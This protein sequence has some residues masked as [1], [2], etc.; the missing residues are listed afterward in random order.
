MK[1]VIIRHLPTY[2]NMEDLLQGTQDIE[3]LP[4]NH[5][6]N[7]EIKKNRKKL[8]NEFNFD[9]VLCS[10]LKRTKQ[11]ANLYGYKNL[12]IDPLLNELNFGYFEGKEKSELSKVVNWVENPRDVVLGES[13]IDFEKRIKS[14]I[15]KYI[16]L[17][18]LLIFGH[19]AW[20]RGLISINKWGNINKMNQFHINNNEIIVIEG[21][22]NE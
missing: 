20:I 4:P 2:W 6:H 18:T 3:V 5:Y 19:G 15:D 11:T 7:C 17:D 21:K 10:E 9:L 1:I 22:E 13:L 14:F 8:K 12:I 16:T